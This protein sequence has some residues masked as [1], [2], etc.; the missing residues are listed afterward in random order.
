MSAYI[1][2]AGEPIRLTRGEKL[3]TLEHAAEIVDRPVE[4]VRRVW[5]SSGVRLRNGTHTLKLRTVG[6]RRSRRTTVRAVQDFLE[7]Y[8][9]IVSGPEQLRVPEPND[10]AANLRSEVTRKRLEGL[11][12]VGDAPE[13]GGFEV[14][15]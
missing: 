10:Q 15:A 2:L 13:H 3:I 14:V 7:R 6:Q 8:D 9:Q 1:E 11:H 4:I 12:L 5:A